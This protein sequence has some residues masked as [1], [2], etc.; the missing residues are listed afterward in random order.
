MASSIQILRSTVARE[1]PLPEGLLEGQPAVNLNAGEPG[2]FFKAADGSLVKIGP[3]AITY[4]GNPPNTP[5]AGNPG[6]CVGELWLDAS[7]TPNVLKIFDGTQWR[8]AS[9]PNAVDTINAGSGISVQRTGNSV[10][11]ANTGVTSLIAGANITLS[12]SSGQVTISSTGGGGGGSTSFLRWNYTA[13]GGETSLSGVSSG[14]ALVYTPGLEEV[15]INGVLLTRDVDYSAT[16]GSSI[17]GLAPLTAGDIVTV[18]SFN[19]GEIFQ[20]PGEA[21]LLR[22]SISASAGQTILTGNDT[23][24]VALAYTPGLEEVYVNG[25]FMRRGVDYTASNGTSITLT[26]P[27]VAGY[28]VTVLG[29][30]AF[31]VAD[32]LPAS[33]VTYT[34]PGSGAVLRNTASKLGDIAS[35]KD[36]GAVGDGVTND[37][38]AVAAAEASTFPRIYV[39]AGRYLTTY[40]PFQALNKVYEGPGQLIVGGYGSACERSGEVSYVA[41]PA[42][43]NRYQIFDQLA[44]QVPQTAYRYIGP[45][46]TTPSPLPTIYTNYPQY[47]QSFNIFDYTAGF[48]TDPGDHVNGR[49]GAFAH[50]DYVY[51]GGQGDL[52]CN[53]YYGEIYSNRSGATHWLANPAIIRENGGFGATG[54][55]TG[56]YLNHSE[57]IYSDGGLSVAVIDRVRNYDRTNSNTSLYQVWIHDRPQSRTAAHPIDSVY[58]IAGFVKVGLDFTPATLTASKAAIALKQND[59]IYFG[60]SASVDPVGAQWYADNLGDAFMTYTGTSIVTAVNGNPSL[61]VTSGGIT[62]AGTGNTGLVF[63]NT[64]TMRFAGTNQYSTGGSTASFS[65]TNKPGGVS[66]S[67]PAQWLKVTLGTTDYYIPCWQ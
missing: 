25:V 57:Y 53:T 61:Q 16:N 50:V 64:A 19:P 56:A 55:A 47:A 2:L 26:A 65:A 62:I 34:P 44:G 46:A 7:T 20:L 63:G 11:V 29:W 30:S 23:N 66:G 49:S 27:L 12:G 21:S 22:W 45:G 13:V 18:L 38:A 1:R 37:T 28:D 52:T 67:G 17:T 32:T 58:S 9:S 41:P 42:T 54:S 51:H 40:T 48:N 35:L 33:Q 39:P 5:S 43:Y 10:T 59:R 14:V 60:A 31:S 4:D 6:H 24:N 8:S 36:F 15:F 3:A